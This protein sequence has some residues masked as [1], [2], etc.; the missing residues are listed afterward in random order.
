MLKTA[1]NREIDFMKHY[2]SV[3][4]GLTLFSPL[5]AANLSIKVPN[6]IIRDC[7]KIQSVENSNS[8]TAT[9][10]AE[11]CNCLLKRSLSVTDTMELIRSDSRLRL[12][13]ESSNIDL[14][15]QVVIQYGNSASMTASNYS[16]QAVAK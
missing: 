6:D 8:N 2:F 13:C 4:L 1:S 14:G 16:I 10:A 5:S 3:L 11:N 7:G 9:I 12:I 15:D